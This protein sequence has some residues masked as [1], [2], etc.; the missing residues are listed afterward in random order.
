MQRIIGWEDDR[1]HD[2]C[3]ITPFFLVHLL[4]GIWLASLFRTFFPS[5]KQVFLAVLFV[6]TLY[7]IKDY[8]VSYVL[9]LGQTSL[10]NSIG[11]TIAVIMGY[12]VYKKYP[13]EF[14][15]I[16]VLYLSTAVIFKALERF[17]SNRHQVESAIR[18]II[19]KTNM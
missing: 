14:F 3:L 2:S 18:A 12:C 13:L 19:K 11:D 8:Y 16:S 7:E 10:W 1:L 5:V 17:V 15:T 6:H 4:S 9:K